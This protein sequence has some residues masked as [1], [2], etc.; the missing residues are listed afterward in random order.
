MSDVK[1][2]YDEFDGN[3]V[4]CKLEATAADGNIHYTGYI[5]DHVK[6]VPNAAI[7]VLAVFQRLTSDP[8]FNDEMMDW[9]N[10]QLGVRAVK[11]N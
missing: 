2:L 11:D 3:S 8:A 1:K 6:V 10:S 7:M 4:A 9:A 5:P